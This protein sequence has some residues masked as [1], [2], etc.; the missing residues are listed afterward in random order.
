MPRFGQAELV[1]RPSEWTETDDSAADTALTVTKAGVTGQRHYVTAFEAVLRAAAATGD[2]KVAVQDGSTDK[3]VTYFGDAAVRG[4][5]VG[6]VFANPLRITAGA[7]AKVVVAAAGA[8]AI[9]TATLSGYT[10]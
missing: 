7:D 8:S 3:W 1:A 10:R 2:V 5:R 4:E 9:V 6:V